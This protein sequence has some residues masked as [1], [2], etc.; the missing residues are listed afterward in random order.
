MFGSLLLEKK[1]AS[2]GKFKKLSLGCEVQEIG[3]IELRHELTHLN[4]L[5]ELVVRQVADLYKV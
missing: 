2:V 3:V 4:G 5:L 1:Q